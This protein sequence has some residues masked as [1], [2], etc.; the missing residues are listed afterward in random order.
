[1]TTTKL[2]FHS[3]VRFLR[4]RRRLSM[5]DFS[6]LLDISR[7]KLQAIEVGRTQNPTAVDLINFSE[8]LKIS[9]DNLMKVDLR[10]LTEFSLR[11]LEA[12][13]DSYTM[14]KKLRVLT[15]TVDKN[16][17]ENVEMIPVRAKAGYAAGY[18]DPV[19][20]ASLQSFSL[21]NL[22]RERTY[23]MF[24][25]TGESMLPIPE[26]SII[27]AS[28]VQDWKSIK[29]DTLCVIILKE[30]GQDMVFKSVKN[31]IKQY[32]SLELHSLNPEFKPYVVQASEILEIWMFEQYLSS[33]V[34]SV[35]ISMQTITSLL[36][37]IKIDVGKLVKGSL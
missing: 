17:K 11:E 7:T 21:P 22:K 31:H 10:S 12:G 4:E 32:G 16:N 25:I 9:I 37:G 13:N 18:N 20:I 15:T 6:Q 27:V 23:R 26:N 14:G 28:F 19:Y 5:E 24:P 2:F 35:D 30:I 1:M 8:Y 36:Q 34:P 3:N 33:T 29:D